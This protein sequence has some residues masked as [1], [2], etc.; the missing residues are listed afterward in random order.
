MDKT[1]PGD[2]SFINGIDSSSLY[3]SRFAMTDETPR[4][5]RALAASR[6]SSSIAPATSSG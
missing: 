3:G 1:K 6:T 2:D 4:Y 5:N